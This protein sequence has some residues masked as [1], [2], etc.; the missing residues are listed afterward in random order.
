[1]LASSSAGPSR[2]SSTARQTLAQCAS[3]ASPLSSR[4]RH[5]S[6]A[7]ARD[8]PKETQPGSTSARRS[9]TSKRGAA[10]AQSDTKK[11]VSTRQARLPPPTVPAETFPAAPAA[12]RHKPVGS[13][14]KN[15]TPRSATG[16]A[17]RRPALALSLATSAGG[18]W[19]SSPALRAP[20][21]CRSRPEAPLE[22][23]VPLSCTAPRAARRLSASA[24]SPTTQSTPSSPRCQPWL[25][26]TVP[27]LAVAAAASPFVSA[28]WPASGPGSRAAQSQTV[29]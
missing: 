18:A 2:R 12:G 29:K 1:M 23:E 27:A 25:A 3:T 22:S 26:R 6:L 9:T 13:L 8:Q 19:T 7:P 28:S 5:A 21:P 16:R 4:A 15:A 11:R 17:K 10:A 14:S 20:R 24:K